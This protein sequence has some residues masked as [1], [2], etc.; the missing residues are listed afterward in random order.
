MQTP[1]NKDGLRRLSNITAYVNTLLDEPMT[2]RQ[3]YQAISDGDLPGGVFRKQMIASKAALRAA[4][5]SRSKRHALAVKR[6]VL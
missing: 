4:I 5:E 3:V 6:A 1:E 2:E